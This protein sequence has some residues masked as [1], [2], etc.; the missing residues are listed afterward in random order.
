MV[1]FFWKKGY[2]LNQYF[3]P[4]KPLF[5]LYNFLHYHYALSVCFMKLMVLRCEFIPTNP[6]IYNYCTVL[7]RKRIFS[8]SKSVIIQTQPGVFKFILNFLIVTSYPVLVNIRLVEAFNLILYYLL[9]T[10]KGFSLMFNKPLYRRTRGRTYSP[11]KKNSQALKF[12]SKQWWNLY[13]L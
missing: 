9:R 8:S 6:L 12:V 11:N 4:Y 13:N 10:Y 5:S 2:Y 1:S 3:F 7:N